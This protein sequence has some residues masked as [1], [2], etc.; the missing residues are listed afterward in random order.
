M[1]VKT[2]FLRRKPLLRLLKNVMLMPKLFIIGRKN[3]RMK[4]KAL[5]KKLLQQII[6]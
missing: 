2:K 1:K 4:L 6:D 5:L 3:F